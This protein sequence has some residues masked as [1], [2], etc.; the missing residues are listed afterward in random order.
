MKKILISILFF[1][2]LLFCFPSSALGSVI[3][4]TVTI[5][6]VQLPQR[7]IIMSMPED[8][9][10]Y[11]PDSRIIITRHSD[12]AIM[13]V[14]NLSSNQLKMDSSTTIAFPYSGV[15]AP[16]DIY[17]E[18]KVNT[19][20]GTTVCDAGCGTVTSGADWAYLFGDSLYYFY[21]SS[22]FKA[23]CPSSCT[24]SASNSSRIALSKNKVVNGYWRSPSL[25]TIN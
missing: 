23:S 4:V 8:T 22:W 6:G 11:I 20:V 12:G 2:A 3:E 1:A 18:V 21:G 13:G 10:F 24:A 17:A 5:T 15:L 25:Y 19:T 9:K 7:A 14:G 16:Y